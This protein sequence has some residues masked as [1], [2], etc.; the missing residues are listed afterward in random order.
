MCGGSRPHRDRAHSEL[1]PNTSASAGLQ[2][3][4]RLHNCY[5]HY[6]QNSHA[7]L[8]AQIIACQRIAGRTRE[9]GLPSLARS[10]RACGMRINFGR[11]V[12]SELQVKPFKTESHISRPL[13][14]AANLAYTFILDRRLGSRRNSGKFNN[15]ECFCP[16][17]NY[18]GKPEGWNRA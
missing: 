3:P 17:Q 8:C 1:D 18:P 9:S 4:S 5:L 6:R 10:C 14:S 11:S 2:F 15:L 7:G 12:G 16:Y 13:S